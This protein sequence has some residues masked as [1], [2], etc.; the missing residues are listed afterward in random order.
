[1][2]ARAA[3]HPRHGVGGRSV[4]PPAPSG[5]PAN[6]SGRP[7]GVVRAGGPR[8]GR[9]EAARPFVIALSSMP[10]LDRVAPATAVATFGDEEAGMRVRRV[11]AGFAGGDGGG[12]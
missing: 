3:G 8:G 2:P 5:V 9:S 12:G 11:R 7:A 1:M 6:P 4:S 10:T